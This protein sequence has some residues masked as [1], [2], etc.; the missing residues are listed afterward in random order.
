MNEYIN[1]TLK[2]GS[3]LLNIK[4]K[5]DDGLKLTAPVKGKMGK[6]IFESISTSSTITLK[7]DDEVIFG[8]TSYHCGLEIVKD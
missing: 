3:Y 5:Y 1:L 2:R 4:A 6:D 7:K 8:D